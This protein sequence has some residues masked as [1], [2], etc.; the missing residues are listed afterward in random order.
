MLAL[1]TP[2]VMSSLRPRCGCASTA[3]IVQASCS[4]MSSDPQLTTRPSTGGFCGGVAIQWTLISRHDRRA[5]H[6]RSA[7]MPLHPFDFPT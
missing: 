3:K 5:E 7:A 6:R 4:E 1:P 2:A